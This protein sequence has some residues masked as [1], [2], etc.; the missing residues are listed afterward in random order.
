M[1]RIYRLRRARDF[2]RLRG[3]AR[4]YVHPLLVLR[5][6]PNGLNQVRVGITVGRKVGTAVQRNRIKRRL[7]ELMRHRLERLQPGYD[8]WWIA[9]ARAAT[10][11]F[12]DLEA[13][14]DTLLG[15]AKLWRD[16][17]TLEEVRHA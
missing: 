1:K 9:R 3:E 17:S 13:A 10:A 2:Q 14:L 4:A 12:K 15:R 8:L 6:A 5:V 11:S 7:R 16:P